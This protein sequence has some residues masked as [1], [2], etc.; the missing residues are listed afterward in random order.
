MHSDRVDLIAKG[1]SDSE[2]TKLKGYVIFI[3]SPEYR[4]KGDMN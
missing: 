4:S 1:D 2:V 3:G